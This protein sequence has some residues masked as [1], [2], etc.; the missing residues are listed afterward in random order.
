[1]SAP[2]Q[3]S[4]R[5]DSQ[6]SSN[7]SGLQTWLPK[8]SLP[9]TPKVLV[10]PLVVHRAFVFHLCFAKRCLLVIQYWAVCCMDS[11]PVCLLWPCY[12][13][14]SW[15]LLLTTVFRIVIYL[16]RVINST[17]FY[18]RCQVRSVIEKNCL[19]VC[20][21]YMIL[22]WNNWILKSHGFWSRMSKT[23]FRKCFLPVWSMF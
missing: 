5:M 11:E 2:L 20:R 3:T 17:W 13:R 18:I 21:I 19:N 1:M 23:V 7:P 4:S 12:F 14:Y 6:Y 15:T 9:C 10:S 22:L 8:H 16:N